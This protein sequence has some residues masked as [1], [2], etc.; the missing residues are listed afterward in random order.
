V[1]RGSTSR[2]APA[3]AAPSDAQRGRLAACRYFLPLRAA[4][5]SAPGSASSPR[6]T[7]RVAPSRRIVLSVS[8]QRIGTLIWVLIFG[9]LFVVGIGYRPRSLGRLVRLELHRRRH[10]RDRRRC[11]LVWLRS[12]SG[13]VTIESAH[14]FSGRQHRAPHSTLFDLRARPRS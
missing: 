12:R 14:R 7:T 2:R 11:V 8:T 6:A 4:E 9:G 13:A 1:D 5:E 3:A 10:R